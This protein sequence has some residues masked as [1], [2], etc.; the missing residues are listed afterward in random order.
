M[1]N[2]KLDRQ[3]LLILGGGGHA[4][5]VIDVMKGG[6]GDLLGYTDLIDYGNICGIP[7]LGDDCV[8]EQEFPDADLII[9]VI[10]TDTVKDLSLRYQLIDRYRYKFNFPVIVSK[11]SILADDVIIEE[12]S[13]V[14]HRV[15]IGPHVSMGAY[16]LINTAAV[17]EHDCRIAD[18]VVV[19][20]GAVVGGGVVIG[21]KSFVGLGAVVIDG[22]NIGDDCII[23]A[24]ALVTTSIPDGMI[25][26]GV[27]AKIKPR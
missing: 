19:S 21:K 23:G 18:H 5:S 12:G 13:V 17:I 16:T 25:A 27:P 24:G 8:I 22:V 6:G 14:M 4:T 7:Y 26:M 3:R 11:T 1:K 10:Y 9:G 2:Q 20:S 15:V